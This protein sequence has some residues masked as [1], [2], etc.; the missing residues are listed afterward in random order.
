MKLCALEV[1][2]FRKF[3]RPI[4][5]QGLTDGLNLIVGPN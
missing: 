2:Q 5:V 3:D 4:R 1:D